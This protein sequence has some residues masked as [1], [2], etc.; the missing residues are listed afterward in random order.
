MVRFALLT[1]LAEK[2]KILGRKNGTPRAKRPRAG[3]KIV[4]ENGTVRYGTLRYGI[5]DKFGLP[6]VKPVKKF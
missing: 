2:R 6:T 3:K 5:E 1:F 4:T